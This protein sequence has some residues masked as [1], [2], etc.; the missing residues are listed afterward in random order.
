M[1]PFLG[2]KEK[3]LVNGLNRINAPH[4]LCRRPRGGTAH[5]PP[6]Q[7]QA[8]RRLA[9]HGEEVPVVQ[10]SSDCLLPRRR[11]VKSPCRPRSEQTRSEQ[12]CTRRFARP[13]TSL[14]AS[15]AQSTGRPLSRAACVPDSYLSRSSAGAGPPDSYSSRCSC[16]CGLRCL[17][18]TSSTSLWT[19]KTSNPAPVVGSWTPSVA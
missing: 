2:D 8:R 4:R 7:T 10:R 1:S 12:R 19:R 3:A 6:S 9:R 11:P 14:K 18:G 5:L 13:A 16:V 15:D 17:R